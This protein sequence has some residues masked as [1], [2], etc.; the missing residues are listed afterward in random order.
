MGWGWVG[1]GGAFWSFINQNKSKLGRLLY[2]GR[3]AMVDI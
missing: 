3:V 2:S 1:G